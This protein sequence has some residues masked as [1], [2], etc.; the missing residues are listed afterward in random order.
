MNRPYFFEFGSFL[1]VAIA[2]TA[3]GGQAVDPS[4]DTAGSTSNTSAPVG[5][6]PYDAGASVGVTTFRMQASESD[7]A[8]VYASSFANP[9]DGVWWYS[10]ATSSGEPLDIFMTGENP[11]C[12]TCGMAAVPIGSACG[13]LPQA[14]VTASWDGLVVLGGEST[15][16]AGTSCITTAHVPEGDYVVT[17]CAGCP[18]L[19]PDAA[20][21]CVSVPFHYPSGGD[22]VGT[23]P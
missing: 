15:C 1:S 23:L 9:G 19:Q 12:E 6:P 5:A 11:Y 20:S 22:I 14:G 18:D 16:G 8:Y 17:M 7:V 13:T 10:V 21:P 4:P 3:C 2:L